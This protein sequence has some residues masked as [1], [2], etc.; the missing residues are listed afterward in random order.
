MKNLN[1]YMNH[2]HL[3]ISSRSLSSSAGITRRRLIL[4]TGSNSVS[5]YNPFKN[6]AS[7]LKQN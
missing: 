6:L 1:N 4:T 3:V 2:M 5:L 7:S